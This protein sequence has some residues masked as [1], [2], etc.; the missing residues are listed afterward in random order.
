MTLGAYKRKFENFRS[1]LMQVVE[2][3]VKNTIDVVIDLNQAQLLYGRD[4]NG[5][6]LTPSYPDDPYFK[7]DKE[8]AERY[9]EN[10]NRM[11]SNH[12]ER[13]DHRIV[14]LMGHIQLFPEKPEETPNLIINGMWFH[15]FFYANA[16]GGKYTIGSTGIKADAIQEKYESYGH[17]V[18]G[19]AKPSRDYYFRGFI[20]PAILR[21]YK[22]HIN[23]V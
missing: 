9:M 2:D 7:G 13:R 3:E 23:G 6:L 20:K 12:K 15:N 11:L 4:A 16:S 10:K 22:Q 8:A 18:F 19:L 21:S 14:P 17:P 5:E 1:G